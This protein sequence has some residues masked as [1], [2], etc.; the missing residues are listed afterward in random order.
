[1]LRYLLYK[2]SSM[3][4]LIAYIKFFAQVLTGASVFAESLIPAS[5]ELRDKL[6]AL[7]EAEEPEIDEP[8]V[9]PFNQN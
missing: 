5:D 4:K 2:L 1:M 7:R 8:I 3:R 9:Q 6:K